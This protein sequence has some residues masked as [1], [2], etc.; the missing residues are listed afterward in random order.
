MRLSVR[1]IALIPV[2]T[3]L[4]AALGLVS[5]PIPLMPVPITGQTLGVMLAGAVLGSRRGAA[6]MLLLIL[7]AAV[8]APVL[9]G[10]A[11]GLAKLVGPT[12]GYIWA[13]PIAAWLIGAVCER[14]HGVNVYKLFLA[15]AAASIV[16]YLIG[17]PVLAFVT[18]MP[19]AKA[20]MVGAVPFLIGDLIKC[21]VAAA[22][23]VS[24]ARVLPLA[25]ARNSA[26]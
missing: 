14:S 16:I 2:M 10:G 11:G 1:D 21:A 22:V 12:A 3:A 23:A 15:N 8:G 4:M 25:G 24:L 20:W 9:A 7:L 5:V 6:S 17:V 13:W 19:W 26:A 18:H